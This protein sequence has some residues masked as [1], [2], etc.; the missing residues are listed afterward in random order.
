[1]GPTQGRSRLRSRA[2]P[3]AFLL[4]LLQSVVFSSAVSHAGQPEARSATLPAALLIVAGAPGSI[5]DKGP[6]FSY[7]LYCNEQGLFTYD[8]AARA[9]IE[10]PAHLRQV[11]IDAARGQARAK[12]LVR[13]LEKV[14]HDLGTL[15]AD[16]TTKPGC[17]LL[18]EVTPKCGLSWQFLSDYLGSTAEARHLR[19]VV[20]QAYEV[21][22]RKR[23]AQNAAIIEGVKLLG[24]LGVAAA[25]SEAAVV[26]VRPP[27]A[28]VSVESAASME[29]T[30]GGGGHAANRLKPDPAAEGAHSTFKRDPQTGKVTG[31]AEWQPNPRNPSGFDQAKRVDVTGDPHF[32]KATRQD[33]PTPHVHEKG[34]P[35]G[36][37][38]A[39]PDEVPQ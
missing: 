3:P 7:G 17:V 11:Y 2:R 15:V 37:R 13:E 38:P 35:G 33:V 27:A 1:M 4:A 20:I 14:F 5:E 39:R 18:P 23:G 10:R 25:A 32:N 26:P 12:V 29:R 30:A 31:Q 19:D 6:P 9:L 21:E 28:K 22:A 24:A 16:E 8:G 36:V 34:V